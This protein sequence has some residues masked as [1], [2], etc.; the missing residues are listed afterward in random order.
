MPY[1]AYYV[2][3]AALAL[4][5]VLYFFE[6]RAKQKKW[7]CA[8]AVFAIHVFVIVYF[9]FIELGMESLLVFLMASLVLSLCARPTKKQ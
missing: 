8:A 4:C 5:A 6:N 1:I 7:V 2:P 9:W 3:A